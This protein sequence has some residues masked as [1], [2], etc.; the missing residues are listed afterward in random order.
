M[1]AKEENERLTRVGPGTPMGALLRRYWW[2]VGFAEHVTSRPQR[3]TRLGQELVLYRGADGRPG[4]M[5]LRCAHRGVALDYGRVE[6]ECLRCPYHG[7]LYDRAGRCVEQPAEPQES[8]FKDRIRLGAYAVQEYGGL[9]FGYLGPDP[10]PLL[11]RY[12]VMSRDDGIKTLQVRRANCNWLQ[13]AENITDITHL[14]W[15]H[16]ATFPKYGARAL[17]YDWERTAWGAKNIMRVEGVEQ[18]HVSCYVFPSLN[19]FPLAPIDGELVR[20]FIY[21]VPVDDVSSLVYMIRFRPGAARALQTLGELPAELGV[22][23]PLETDWW[24][25]DFFDQDRMAV[26]QQGVVSN[27]EAEHLSASDRG[28]ILLR[29]MLQEGLA[30]VEAG[31]DPL[32]VVRDEASNRVIVFDTHADMFGEPAG[33]AA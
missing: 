15:L 16:G 6:G 29:Q 3:L 28:I 8:T 13:V 25:I 5:D 27:R 23:R 14:A 1:L 11:P 31:R 7:W 9:V 19:R 12:D 30:A 21:R 26:E 22:Y 2:P 33:R 4:L 18:E 17:S 32:G 20:A 24:G 10:A